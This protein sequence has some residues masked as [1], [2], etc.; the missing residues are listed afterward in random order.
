MPNRI[1]KESI[2]ESEKLASVKDFDFRLWVCLITQAD[3]AG[4]GDAR[5]AII[6]GRCFPLRESVTIKSISDSLHALASNGLIG[7]YEVGGRPFYWFPSW[8]EHQRVRDCKPK[9]PAPEESDNLR[10]SAASCRELSQVAA[11]CGSNPIQYESNTN[12]NPNPN[13]KV[14]ASALDVALN[15]FAEMRK[16]MRKPLT[17]RALSLTLAELEK[18][19][20]GDDEKKIAILNQSI[21]RG[22]QGVFPLK[23]EPEA[24]KKTAPAR[25]PHG[26]DS[27]RLQR[28]L[29]NIEKK[30][31]EKE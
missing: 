9:Y 10:Q 2:C 31:N 23:D 3:D 29:A 25:M 22:W 1:I 28:I 15:D 7:L 11:S 12:P 18:L 30:Q 19:A 6:K 5:P 24:P 8:T 27:E 13:P 14:R 21:Q 26:D 4:R 20:P 17:D 16:K